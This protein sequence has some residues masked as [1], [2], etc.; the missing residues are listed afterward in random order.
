MV[1]VYPLITL[2]EINVLVGCSTFFRIPARRWEGVRALIWKKTGT[3]ARPRPPRASRAYNR[4]GI[5]V[6]GA[7]FLLRARG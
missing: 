1:L 6:V 3:Y 7:Y 2:V 4:G 5:S